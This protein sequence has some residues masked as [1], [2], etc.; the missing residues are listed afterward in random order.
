METV[1]IE[2]LRGECV[3]PKTS[4]N[5]SSRRS[6]TSRRAASSGAHEIKFDGYR[7]VC[8]R[9]GAQ[10]RIYTRNGNDWTERF[11][12]LAKA[13]LALKCKSV[14]IDGEIVVL[15][16]KGVGGFAR[17]QDA[18]ARKNDLHVVYY[19]FD[20]LQL[21]GEDTRALALTLRKEKLKRLLPAKTFKIQFSDHVVG[22]GAKVLKQ[23]CAIGLEGIVS[24]RI[25]APYRPDR[26][27]DWQKSKCLKRQEFVIVGY[28]ERSNAKNDFGSL[29][30]GAH[31]GGKLVYAGHV[32]TGLERPQPQGD[33]REPREAES[34]KAHGDL[35]RR[36]I[37]NRR[38]LGEAEACG[39]GCLHRMDERRRASPPLVSRPARRQARARRGDGAADRGTGLA[40][41]WELAKAALIV[42][43]LWVQA[44]NIFLLGRGKMRAKRTIFKKQ[45]ICARSA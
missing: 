34:A 7:M 35:A 25:D 23:A 4:P 36:R 16:D 14:L 3:T 40:R 21:D 17:L 42:A 22:D 5:P 20:L 13:V 6:S 2:D 18:I 45:E 38:A 26:G 10:V 28:S 27:L 39:G 31:E 37:F 43:R 15:D 29:L 32:G 9:D 11:P 12:S 19:A 8:W 33:L 24:T 1:D 41:R 30:L 44:G